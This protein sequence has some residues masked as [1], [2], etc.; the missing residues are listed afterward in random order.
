MSAAKF[1]VGDVFERMAELE[2]GSVDL[3]LMENASTLCGSSFGLGVRRHRLFLSNVPL[4]GL[5]C[6]HKR[7]GR[8]WGVYHV[9]NDAIPKG[10]RTALNVE[11]GRE[12]MGVTRGV[13]W[14]GL[15][16]GVPPAFTKF[17]GDQLMAYV[18][19]PA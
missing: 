4:F 15:K 18:R 12:V 9:P 10:G 11:H 14:K 7:Q 8:P 3:I 6:D 16:E 2:D 13:S 5:P 1:L 17:I 19:S